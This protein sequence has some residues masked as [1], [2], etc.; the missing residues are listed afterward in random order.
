MSPPPRWWCCSLLLL[1]FSAPLL[2]QPAL[3]QCG[4]LQ[5]PFPFYLNATGTAPPSSVLSPAFSLSCVNSSALFLSIASRTYRVLHF[6]PDGVL[7][8]FPNAT[9]C[10]H[11]NDLRSFALSANPYFAISADNVLDLYDCDDSSLCKPDCDR[12][13][14]V[15]GCDGQPA[16]YPSCCYPLSDR[17]GSW[18]PGET[19]AAFSQYGCRGFSSWVVLPGSKIGKRGVKLEWGVPRNS[20]GGGAASCA[21]NADIVNAT[22]VDAG[23]RCQCADGFSGDGFLAGLGCLKCKSR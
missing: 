9:V 1:H 15:P 8:D 18:R 19:L 23:V 13:S 10:R 6:F 17:S 21:A 3:P 4:G 22:S 12:T 7:V 5:I 20:S 14:V 16:G 2:A 11:Y